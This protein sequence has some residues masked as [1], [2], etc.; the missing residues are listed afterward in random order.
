[1][2]LALRVPW[3]WGNRAAADVAPWSIVRRTVHHRATVA[4]ANAST[5]GAEP[6][7]VLF[8]NGLAASGTGKGGIS[9]VG[10]YTTREVLSLKPNLSIGREGAPTDR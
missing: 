2:S 5:L 4:F 10:V 6:F 8:R 9:A 1:L 3:L 7:G